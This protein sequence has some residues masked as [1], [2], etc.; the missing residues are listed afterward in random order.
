MGEEYSDH[1]LPRNKY[2]INGKHVMID[3]EIEELARIL[4]IYLQS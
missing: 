3:D 2:I 4:K 1:P